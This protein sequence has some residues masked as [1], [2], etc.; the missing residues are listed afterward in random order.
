[1]SAHT[2]FYEV[3][4]DP[5]VEYIGFNKAWIKPGHWYENAVNGIDAPYLD[6]GKVVKTTDQNGRPIIIIGHEEGN[7]VIFQCQY[8]E[9]DY[10]AILPE[11]ALDYAGDGLLD[12][13]EMFAILGISGFENNLVRCLMQAF[14]IA[15]ER[16][17]DRFNEVF[18]SEKTEEVFFNNRWYNLLEGYSGMVNKFE[19][20]GSLSLGVIYKTTNLN[21]GHRLLIIPSPFGNIICFRESPDQQGFQTLAPTQLRN[22]IPYEVISNKISRKILGDK[23]NDEN[24]VMFL[25]N[26]TMELNSN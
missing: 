5:K 1:M 13:K 20:F 16:A 3:F 25:L 10:M 6:N 14:K 19:K 11:Y 26:L 17:K 2:R 24:I 15:G 8:K 9:E 21:T 12:E 18:L 22:F 4:D 7:I 23:S